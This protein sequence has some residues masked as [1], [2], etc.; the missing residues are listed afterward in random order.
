MPQ[1]RIL[2]KSKKP[3]GCDW[4]KRWIEP[5]KLKST[6]DGIPYPEVIVSPVQTGEGM[7]MRSAVAVAVL[8]ASLVVEDAGAANDCSA[9]A[10]NYYCTGV[11]IALS[12]ATE[13]PDL[14]SALK[15]KAASYG[16]K[17]GHLR[18]KELGEKY[19]RKGVEDAADSTNPNVMQRLLATCVSGDQAAVDEFI[20][21]TRGDC[22][23][24]AGSSWQK[25]K[26]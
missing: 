21:K 26:Q 25:S 4:P 24:G 19:Q 7:M 1:H 12:Q 10:L 14:A 13:I 18:H 3:T 9:A 2:Q 15:S 22:T 8:M 16:K 23:A 5:Q 11:T 17:A 6:N 20:S